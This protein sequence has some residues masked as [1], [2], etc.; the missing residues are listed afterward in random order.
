MCDHG[1]I[2]HKMKSIE[3]VVILNKAKS[4]L[5]KIKSSVP[6]GTVLAMILFLNLRRHG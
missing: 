4:S 1:V 6:Q 3:H 5:G 2:V